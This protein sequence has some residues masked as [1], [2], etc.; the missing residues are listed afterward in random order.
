M[1]SND[2]KK[3]TREKCIEEIDKILDIYDKSA[4][5]D[6]IQYYICT[7][8][9][10]V[11]CNFNTELIKKM[12]LTTEQDYFVELFLNQNKYY[13]LSNTEKFIH[14]D[15]MNYK[16]VSEDDLLQLILT[17]ISKDAKLLAPWKQRT[18][19]VIMKR[20]KQNNLLVSIPESD[21]IQM[22]LSLLTDIF[23]S[24]DE[25]KYFLTILGD[26]ILKKNTNLIH[27]MDYNIKEFV[28]NINDYCQAIIGCNCINTIKY[29]FYDHIF[30]N[31]RL[32]NNR[33]NFHNNTDWKNTMNGSLAI[34]LFTV[35][36]HY[37]NKY[38]NSDNCLYENNTDESIIDHIFYLKDLTSDNIIADFINKYI[39]ITLKPHE[40]KNKIISSSIDITQINMKDMLYLWKRYLDNQKIPN[41][42]FS[43][44][45]KT[46]IIK[47]FN[48]YYYE[49]L[50]S[51]IGL[52]SKHLPN[53]QLFLEYWN[54][55]IE[56]ELC[57]DYKFE[58][59]EIISLFKI[60]LQTN[61]NTNINLSEKKVIDIIQYFYPDNTII[62]N[63]YVSF[64][65]HKMWNKDNDI[66]KTVDAFID[67]VLSTNYNA[68]GKKLAIYDIYN[69]YCNHYA[70]IVSKKYFE[71]VI[72]TKW[73]EKY[74]FENGNAFLIIP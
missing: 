61:Y 48:E 28:N 39:E 58:V 63:K 27:I 74:I 60:W 36:C 26:N 59:S 71:N 65:K 40:I 57:D 3:E 13:Y 33:I 4:I 34:A 17:T 16:L 51:F 44:T 21:T 2:R 38:K 55:N 22:I 66:V 72:K 50:D 23:N 1:E 62:D 15:N 69:H 32:F 25:V 64:I 29:K 31:T 9:K 42:V 30:S 6:K 73:E 11:I 54:N 56:E 7:Q 24:K 19:N 12:D 45:F 35:A 52:S 68:T 37:S 5:Y 43:N 67:E 46:E 18:K 49:D 10:V 53:T 41:V 20:I 14:Y 8:M 70:L 47:I